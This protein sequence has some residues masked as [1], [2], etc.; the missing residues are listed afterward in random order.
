[1]VISTDTEK[2]FDK[3]LHSF[4]IKTLNRIGRRETYLNT[5]KAIH[6]KPTATNIIN[7]EKLKSFLL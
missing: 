2:T 6:K 5:A 4:M 1:M 3:V 7:G